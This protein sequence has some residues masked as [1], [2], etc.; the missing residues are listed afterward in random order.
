MRRGKPRRTN[1]LSRRAFLRNSAAG[2]AGLATAGAASQGVLA[3]PLAPIP[4][5]LPQDQHAL[6]QWLRRIKR[7]VAVGRANAKP[8]HKS[9]EAFRRLIA[10]D[11]IVRMYVT[12]M[13]EQAP[14]ERKTVETVDELL[15]ALDHIV[16]RAPE[17]SAD[18]AK[19]NFFP[20]S[21]LFG[22]MMF[23]QAGFAAFR[24][25]RINGALR[26]MF[27]DWSDFLDSPASRDVLH[28]GENG[29]LSPSAYADFKLDEFVIPDQNAPHW[30]FKSFN[31]YFHRQIKASR[32]PVAEPDN[33]KVIV[34]ANDGTVYQIGREVKRTDDFW[35]KSQPYS[36]SDMLDDH[37]LT[38]SFVGGDV[39]QTFLSGSSYHRWRSPID[40][41]I[42]DTRLVD[43]LM[44]SELRVMGFDPTEATHSQGFGAS[45]N[46]RALIFVESPDPVIGT[47]CVIPIGIT[48][49]SSITIGVSPGQTVKKGEELGYFSYGGSSMAL[50]FRPGAIKDFSVSA[51]KPGADP[52]SGPPVKV[53]ARIARAR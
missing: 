45:V 7:D 48:E 52:D 5:F 21:A 37:E 53:N 35:I 6:D 40:G 2:A 44:F 31:A 12:Q 26:A 46:T 1:L 32:R 38:D 27:Q 24:D 29:W 23:T 4:G 30:G 22:G 18:P 28:T 8:R 36:L 49:I 11:G 10:E 3:N 50:V 43:G 16:G 25:D 33:P 15:V 41:K 9:V 39:F 34:S 47:V 13:V 14:A 17:Y 42:V 19:R 51:P 20:M